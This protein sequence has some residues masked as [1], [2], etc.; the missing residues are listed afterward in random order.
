MMNLEVVYLT[1][2]LLELP[3]DQQWINVQMDQSSV[4]KTEINDYSINAVG[5]KSLQNDLTQNVS[6]IKF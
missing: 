1:P 3:K 4:F 2:L 5:S 6:L